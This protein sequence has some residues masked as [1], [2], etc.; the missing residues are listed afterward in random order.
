MSQM[1]QFLMAHGGPFLFL[2]VLLDQSG[3]PFPAVPW[4]LAAGALAAGGKLS[5]PSA[6]CWA[7]V[8]SLGA[9]MIWFRLGQRGK[10]RIFRF[11]PDLQSR[12]QT[13]PQK[14]HI[15][16][17]LRGVRVLTTAKFLPF[18]SVVSLRAGALEV[19]TLRF[20]LIDAFSSIVYVSIYV[21]L[22]FFFREQLEQLITLVKRLGLLGFVPL[23]VLV[24]GYF[25]CRFLK[26]RPKLNDAIQTV[27]KLEE[28]HV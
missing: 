20:F 16:L 21:L 4:L 19:G 14:P 22:G 11:F 12:K 23:V 5:L 6:M 2:I 9:D 3:L 28:T 25:C 15:H 13:L 17:I 1:T 8:G 26:R 27:P 18:G 24:A 10:K 7:V